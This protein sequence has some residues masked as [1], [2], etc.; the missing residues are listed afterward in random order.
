[1]TVHQQ[2]LSPTW[3]SQCFIETRM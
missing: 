1:M 2:L 3:I